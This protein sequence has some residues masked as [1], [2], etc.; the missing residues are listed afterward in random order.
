MSEG[1]TEEG[2][3]RIEE[4]IARA[5]HRDL[6]WRKVLVRL[7]PDA[8]NNMV[9]RRMFANAY[10]WP[11]VKHLCDT[12]FAD[13]Y[14]ATT[15]D[16]LEPATDR[17]KGVEEPVKEDGEHVKGQNDA[18]PPIER[19]ESELREVADELKPLKTRQRSHRRLLT[20]DSIRSKDS[21]QWDD[22]YFYGTSDD[23]DDEQDDR[24]AIQ[25]FLQLQQPGSKPNSPEYPKTPEGFGTSNADIDD[26][27]STS[28]PSVEGH[29][30][31]GPSSPKKSLAREPE[32]L[33]PMGGPLL[34]K[35]RQTS[36]PPETPSGTLSGIGLHKS[37]EP[38]SPVSPPGSRAR[39]G[40][41][42]VAEHVA[43][44]SLPQD[45]Q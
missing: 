12:H 9:V 15:R 8:H 6:S 34:G 33:E 20:G 17:A 43:R 25:R 19:T 16:E 13:T 30:G 1:S 24:N 22:A 29:R 42:G 18:Q 35:D 27:L 14:A 36:S 45:H 7:E 2:G 23:D 32:S 39:S 5:Y 4:K 10:G 44:L 28:P 41:G 31:L 26:F 21:A 40:S 38:D 3:M 11:V 37:L